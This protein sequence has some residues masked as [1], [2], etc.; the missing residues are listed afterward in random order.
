MI[1]MKQPFLHMIG[2]CN[3]VMHKL[4]PN[5]SE[6]HS[7]PV[8]IN[9]FVGANHAGNRVT[10]HSHTRILIFLNF[11]LHVWY[12]KSHNTIH[13][14][15]F[16]SEFVAVKIAVE[17]LEALCYKLHVFGIPIEGSANTLLTIIQ[18]C[19]TWPLHYLLLKRSITPLLTTMSV[20]LLLLEYYAY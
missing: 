13:S 17:L 16:G 14:S 5:M 12:S 7:N 8:Q 1:G 2:Y 11:S 3:I 20:K 18:W 10:W 4:P 15:T 9:C 6:P 19:L